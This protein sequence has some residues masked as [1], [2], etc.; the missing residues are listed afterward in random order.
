LDGR[1]VNTLAYYDKEFYDDS[2]LAFVVSPL[3]NVGRVTRT[4]MDG[5]KSFGRNTP[6]RLTFGR[7]GV[8]K[9][10]GHCHNFVY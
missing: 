3:F 5:A 8:K 10:V 1:A 6:S 7:L 4:K 2:P 9:L